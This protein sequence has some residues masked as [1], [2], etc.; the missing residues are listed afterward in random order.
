[1]T[2]HHER[3][4]EKLVDDVVRLW[5]YL[6]IVEKFNWVSSLKPLLHQEEMDIAKMIENRVADENLER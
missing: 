2:Q 6:A 4:I 3:A 5:P 1:M